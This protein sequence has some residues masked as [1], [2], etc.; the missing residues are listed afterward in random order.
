M[1]A[2]VFA[3]VVGAVAQSALRRIGQPDPIGDTAEIDV[4]LAS[5]DSR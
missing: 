5:N 4:F 3:A 1:T 2:M